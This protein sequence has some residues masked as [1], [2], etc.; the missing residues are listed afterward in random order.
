MLRAECPESASELVEREGRIMPNSRAWRGRGWG[1]GE[2]CF[3]E[4]KGSGAEHRQLWT[5]KPQ[6]AR[7]LTSET[8]PKTS[9]RIGP[10]TRPGSSQRA[11]FL[12]SCSP[13]Y[14]GSVVERG[15]RR[16]RIRTPA[17]P[18][19]ASTCGSPT[20][21][22]VTYTRGC[23]MYSGQI[24]VPLYQPSCPTISLTAQARIQRPQHGS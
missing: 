15:A 24:G 3:G 19:D 6:P 20:C 12:A 5:T 10:E 18:C 7:H 14:L 17:C 1:V 8:Q 4:A 13:L 22:S 16:H 2:V 23:C 9:R 11:L 21:R